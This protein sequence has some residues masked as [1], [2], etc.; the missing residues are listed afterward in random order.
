LLANPWPAL[1]GRVGAIAAGK[2][3]D[4]SEDARVIERLDTWARKRWE[5]LRRGEARRPSTARVRG[6][7][8][9]LVTAPD[10]RERCCVVEG[11]QRCTLPSAW[12]VCGPPPG[13]R[14]R[15]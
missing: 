9:S 7:T 10:E 3:V 12:L 8:W 1:E 11:G 13:R 4:L 2:I 5:E 15:P 14:A 6:V